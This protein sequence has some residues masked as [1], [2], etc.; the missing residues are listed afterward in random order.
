MIELARIGG[1]SSVVQ[2]GNKT[3][4]EKKGIYAFLWPNVELYLASN[5]TGSG[6]RAENTPS[7]MD[8][9]LDGIKKLRRFKYDGD[10][11]MPNVY[12]PLIGGKVKRYS[13][14][15]NWVLVDSDDARKASQ[16]MHKKLV[17]DWNTHQYTYPKAMGYHGFDMEWAQVFVPAHKGKIKG[18][19]PNAR[20]VA[21]RSQ[22]RYD[23][24]PRFRRGQVFRTEAGSEIALERIHTHPT[25]ADYVDSVEFKVKS[26]APVDVSGPR[27]FFYERPKVGDK[28]KIYNQDLGAIGWPRVRYEPTFH[29]ASRVAAK[30]KNKKQVDKAD[31]SGKTTVYEYSKGQVDH[32]NREKAKRIEG[33]K[34][35]IL[36]LRSKVQSDLTSDDPKTRL[37]ALAISLMDETCERVGNDESAEERGH[38]GVTTLQAKHVKI[39]GGKATLS[40]TGKSGVKHSKT[41]ENSKA[42]SALKKALNGKSGSDTILCDGDDCTVRADDVNE[43]LKE[44]DITAKDIRGYRAND[45]MVKQLKEQRSKGKELPNDRKGK[46]EILKAEFTKALEA[47]AKVVGHESSTLRSQYLVPKLE[48]SYVHD[49]TVMDKWDK[50]ANYD[51]AKWYYDWEPS[52]TLDT[53]IQRW[54]N[55]EITSQKMYD[56]SMPLMLT[57]RELW[58]HREYTW[59]RENSRRGHVTFNGEDLPG[60]LKWD[61]L[62]EDMKING[63]NP[64]EPLHLTI[65]EK[66]GV[67]VGEGNHRLA[68]AKEIGMSKVPVWFH[69]Y[70]GKVTKTEQFPKTRTEV[71]QK[72]VKR[73]V[74]KAEKKPLRKLTPQEQREIDE[75]MRSI[76][77]SRTAAGKYD[78]INFKPPE[79]VANAAAKGLEYRQKASPSNKGGLTPS[80]AAQEGIGSGVQRAV[81]L[82]NRNTLTPETINK[83][84][85]FFAR[86]EKNK[87]V[88]P[89]NKG[90]PYNDKGHVAWLLWGGDPGKSWCNKV[91]AQMEAADKKSKQASI[92][93]IAARYLTAG[94]N[95]P[96]NPELWSKVVSLTK[97]EI[98]SLT[99]NGETVKGPNNGTGFQKY[100]TA[101]ANGWA[102]KVYGDLGGGWK[103][104]EKKAHLTFKKTYKTAA[105]K[106][107][108]PKL[109]YA[110]DA[111]DP[112]ISEET[113][114]FH[115][116]K[117]HKGYVDGLNA[118]EEALAK[119]KAGNDF[120]TIRQINE[121]IAF[122]W[123]GH[124]LH[125]VYWE[126]LGADVQ[127]SDNLKA[128]IDDAFGS[129]DTFREQ[130][131]STAASVQ[132]S[133][134]AV[135]TWN[136]DTGMQIAGIKN[137]EHRVL[138]D[139]HVVLPLDVW[140]HAYYIDHKNDRAAH[141]E[142][143]FD[144]CVNWTE[145]EKRLSEIKG[146]GK[147]ARGK[148]KKDV[149]HGG[150]DEWFSGHGGSKG[151]GEDATWGDWVSISPVTKTLPSGKKVEKG[152]IVG[153]CGISSDPD[154]KAETK[155]GKNPLKC[156]PRQKA[157]KMDKSERASKA[158][159]KQ[160]AEKSTPNT[161]KPTNTPTFQKKAGLQPA[162]VHHLAD[163]LNIPWDNDPAFLKWTKSVT[164]K[165]HLD[166]LNQGELKSVMKAL[167]QRKTAEVVADL[168]PQLGWPGG[169][170][171]LVNRINEEVRN[172]R[173]RDNLTNKA[174][175]GDKLTNPEAH[176]VYDVER[177]RGTKVKFLSKFHITPHAQY[178]MDQRGITVNDLRVALK[179]FAKAYYD[180]KSKNGYEYRDWSEQMAYGRE[181]RW[182]DERN[183]KLA[184]VFQANGKGDVVIITTYWEGL[185]DPSP[186]SQQ[187]CEVFSP[188]R[189]AARNEWKAYRDSISKHS[190]T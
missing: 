7:R 129:W 175:D 108:L 178:R 63:W 188:Q 64:K 187:Q 13:K 81:N 131:Q 32:R 102:S 78:H 50:K 110:Y 11:W 22:T 173:M 80:Q 5:F 75:L 53:I 8:Q 6:A 141:F 161:K 96:T 189:V 122:H 38:F 61:A 115:H 136:Q 86:H 158:K 172:P 112:W 146:R 154:W 121:D 106:H 29:A 34:G 79:G 84:V 18:K 19:K 147:T 149:G 190:R 185:S 24:K 159:A 46:D 28:I 97:G 65:G 132:G 3:A 167:K 91:K 155:G 89:E 123:G 43:Y 101:Y 55:P 30:Y 31:G 57:V 144:N 143:V 113:L 69:F 183:G 95:E 182:V 127:A 174:L 35:N 162:D 164:G 71:S 56:R 118:A 52:V 54:Q 70:S 124:Y 104:K 138:W 83:M 88:K 9:Y 168:N 59:S 126:C 176:K 58:P 66:G 139:S 107:T 148:A 62:K 10:L 92:F 133:G 128:E 100:P 171:H 36:K 39:N 160:K 179:S 111:L 17:A 93:R 186:K 51:P 103:K 76:F 73:V 94:E 180:S 150:L 44:Y 2:K 142:G 116:D 90:K 1:L 87:G 184:V 20:R 130:F 74:D 85:G 25:D 181:I 134:W 157:H 140:E 135:L 77:A 109:P 99:H 156:M 166:D 145:V 117:H 151:K 137:H 165:E 37:T 163:K 27:A 26:I 47:T 72:A 33:L 15:G 23:A 152:D 82:K 169:T 41:V 170:C 14:D 4:P 21:A 49:G 153:D 120:H 98:K 125:T 60:P 40:Y 45:E 16:R 68:I 105:G 48:D 12:A 42:V 67:K 177:E 114:K 119:A